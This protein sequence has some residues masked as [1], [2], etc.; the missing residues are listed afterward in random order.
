MKD[1]N[2]LSIRLA[3]ESDAA[4]LYI[5]DENPH[6]MAAT[7]NDGSKSFDANW[8]EELLPQQDGTQFFIAEVDGTPIGAMQIINPATEKTQYWGAVA[9][10][11]RAIDIWIGEEAYIGHGYGTLMMRF[12]IERCFSCS[13]VEAILIDPL[14]NNLRSHQ[15]YKR[16]GFV[17]L[18]RRQFDKDSDC[19]VFR[20]SRADWHK[21]ANN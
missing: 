19:F 17:F 13:D 2:R 16:L 10:N 1:E 21:E 20:L 15:F 8:E 6:V 14:A 5:W 4:V 3:T 18:E 11:L 7:S 9:S 12:A